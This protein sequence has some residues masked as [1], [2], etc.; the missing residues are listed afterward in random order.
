MNTYDINLDVPP[1]SAGEHQPAPARKATEQRHAIRCSPL[2][3]A[4]IVAV[5]HQSYLAH[6]G[7]STSSIGLPC[8]TRLYPSRPIAA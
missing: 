1:P 2:A 8:G 5:C 3:H 7:H 4:S 6:H